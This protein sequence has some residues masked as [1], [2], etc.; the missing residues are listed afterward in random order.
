MKMIEI[1][2]ASRATI[3]EMAAHPFFSELDMERVLDK[4]YP[5]K[6]AIPLLWTGN[7][8]PCDTCAV[9]L[10]PLETVLPCR[11]TCVED[12]WFS[13]RGYSEGPDKYPSTGVSEHNIQQSGL[14]QDID[15]FIIPESFVWN[16][17][18]EVRRH[19]RRLLR[20]ATAQGVP[21]AQAS[22]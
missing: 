8:H 4:G 6:S 13:K 22:G 17:D 18:E 11:H 12:N 2:E 21:Q 15:Q 19:E 9:P 3:D 14:M 20:L 16:L 1:R 5:G 7:P 10:P